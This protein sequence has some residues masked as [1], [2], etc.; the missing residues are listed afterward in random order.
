DGAK[1]IFPRGA[2]GK[3]AESLE[4]LVLLLL[5]LVAV[6]GVQIHRVD[7]ALP[8]LD[9]R[10][11][12]RLTAYRQHPAGKVRD[13]AYGRRDGVVDDDQ[14]VIGV[15]RQLV[16]VERP[17]GHPGSAGKL[18]G[19]RPA[20]RGERRGPQSQRETPAQEMPAAERG[21]GSVHEFKLLFAISV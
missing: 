17:F 1:V 5:L 4:I 8:D 20:Y 12:N 21:I 14:V 19:K 15:E 9:H 11:P 10:V 18:F 2:R 16:R 7:V 6:A 3:P 13:F